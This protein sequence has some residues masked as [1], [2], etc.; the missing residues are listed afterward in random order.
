[1]KTRKCYNGIINHCYQR[2]KEKSVLFYSVSDYLVFFTIFCVVASKHQ[3]IVL[4]LVQMP[5]HIHHATIE[6]RKG[7]LSKFVC[8]YSAQYARA[9]NTLCGRKGPLFEHPFQSVPKY[10]DKKARTILLYLDNNPVERRLVQ[11]AEEYRWNYLAYGNSDHPFS[12]KIVLRKA[13]MPL[14]RA[15]D[16]VK[17]QHRAGQP[18]TYP[19]LQNLFKSLPSDAE[20][21]QLTDF[22]VTTYSV[23]DHKSAIRFFDSYEEELI[24]AHANTGSEYDLNE[25]FIGNSD[26]CYNQMSRVLH[27]NGII[28][29]IHEIISMPPSQKQ[30]LFQL[31]RAETFAPAEQI[32]AFL[33]MPLSRVEITD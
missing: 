3:V 18:M 19:L 24:A 27:Q 30:D 26:L 14:R 1:M 11:R 9:F 20:R 12:E 16:R 32:A 23:I 4:K 25:V 6:Q 13:S 2:P 5:D 22:I 10:G 29:D 33:H 7:E 17:A 21:N 31:L 28:Q 8:E 15:L